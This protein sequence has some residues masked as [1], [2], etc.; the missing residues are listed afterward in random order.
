MLQHFDVT[1]L[2][3]PIRLTVHRTF[4]TVHTAMTLEFHRILCLSWLEALP[5]VLLGLR[6]SYKED[7]KAT[8]AD[9]VYGTSLRLPGEF[10]DDNTKSTN[11]TGE[12]LKNL[13]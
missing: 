4:E 7:I 8:A 1:T 12:Y 6:T 13:Q 11:S 10:F 3:V 2:R 9:L 5:S